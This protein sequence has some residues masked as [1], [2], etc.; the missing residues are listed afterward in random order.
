MIVMYFCI[1]VQLKIILR[2]ILKFK[3]NTLGHLMSHYIQIRYKYCKIKSNI[4]YVIILNYNPSEKQKMYVTI[5]MA[6]K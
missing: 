1:I 2:K 5:G 6:A 4:I 3:W